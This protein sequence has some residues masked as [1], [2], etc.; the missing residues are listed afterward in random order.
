MTDATIGRESPYPLNNAIKEYWGDLFSWATANR[1]L[2]YSTTI[3]G[4]PYRVFVRLRTD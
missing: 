1:Q 2:L 4:I 3:A